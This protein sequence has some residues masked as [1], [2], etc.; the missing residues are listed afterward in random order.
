METAKKGHSASYD[1]TTSAPAERSGG[2]IDSLDFVRGVVMILMAIDHVRV[3]AGVPAGGPTPGVFFTRWITHFAAPGFV[4][5]AGTAAYLHGRKLGDRAALSRFLITRGAWLVLL[6]LTVIRVAWTFNFDF[7]NYMLAGVIWML[8]WCMILL[9]VA[10]HLPYVAIAATGV[11]IVA[12]HNVT[13]FFASSLQQ[14]FGEAGPPW[15]LKF[16]YTGGAVQLGG[17]DGP[18]LLVLYVLVPWIGLMMAGYAFGRVME[19]PAERRRSICIKLGLALTALFILLR[20]PN[21]YGDPEPW[22]GSPLALLA[23]TKY[24]ASLAFLLMTIGPLL[25][26]L[27]LAERWRGRVAQV[28]T[29]FGRVPFFYYVLHIPLIHLAAVV[30]S[31]VREGRVNAWLFGNHPMAPPEVP[32]G[33]RWSLTLLYAVFV[34]CVTALYF[35]CRWFAKVRASKR[36]RWL[37]Y[38]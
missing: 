10:V 8:G 29:T 17:P 1:A 15:I 31:L 9:A 28:A 14:S 36:S 19:M 21:L 37:S 18:P 33:Y 32:P 38:L 3:F 30:V 2:R 12:L 20:A 35:P 7:A 22:G 26:L 25:V 24:P 5:L 11:A 13:D 34:I 4:F 23:T 6:E 16:L 27:G